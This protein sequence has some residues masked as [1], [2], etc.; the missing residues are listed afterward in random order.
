MLLLLSNDF[1]NRNINIK[2]NKFFY[3]I[4]LIYQHLLF[5][6]DVAE[7]I[8]IFKREIDISN[9]PN[10]LFINRKIKYLENA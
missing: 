9:S 1:T 3:K 2:N 5:E 6:K 4:Q 7:L 10:S 8:L